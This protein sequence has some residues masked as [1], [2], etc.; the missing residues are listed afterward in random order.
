MV[1]YFIF[2]NDSRRK[3]CLGTSVFGQKSTGSSRCF[4]GHCPVACFFYGL[5][6][7]LSH[8][9]GYFAINTCMYVWSSHIARVRIDRARLP[10]LLVVS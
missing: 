4:F 2:R 10:I 8:G 1:G 7:N 6:R 9:F 3:A 5:L